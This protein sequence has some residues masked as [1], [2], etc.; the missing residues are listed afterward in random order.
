MLTM[1]NSKIYS[2]LGFEVVVHFSGNRVS[3]VELTGR[4]CS[5]QPLPELNISLEDFSEFE[6]KV[7][8]ATM[9][10]PSGRVATYSQLASLVGKPGAARA[11]GRVMAKNPFA[12]VVPCHRVVRSDLSLGGYAYGVELKQAILIA[13]GVKFKGNRVEKIYQWTT[14]ARL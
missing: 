9:K 11:V 2:Y 8:R 4:R 7:L 10:I 5:A 12:V 14:S 6:K 3:G 13:E 1:V